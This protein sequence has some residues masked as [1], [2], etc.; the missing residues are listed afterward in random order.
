MR[1]FLF[2]RIMGF[3]A[4]YGALLLLYSLYTNDCEATQASNIIIKYADDTTVA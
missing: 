4:L 2:E 3:V 1:D